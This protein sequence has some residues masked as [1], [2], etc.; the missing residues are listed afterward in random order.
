MLPRLICLLAF[1][2]CACAQPQPLTLNSLLKEMADRDALAR[3]PSPAYKQGQ[4]S[5]YNRASKARDQADQT[6]SGWFADGDGG[7]YMR[8]ENT[9]A[10][11]ATEYVV[12]EH[13]GP[14]AITK[15]W[16][17]FFYQDFN[18]R[19]GPNIR[20]YLNGSDTPVINENLI[21]LVTRL[22][23]STNE[24][25][26]K[27]SPRNSFTLPSPIAHFTARAGDCYLPVPFSTSCKVTISSAPFY[28]IVSYRAYPTGTLV[29]DFSMASLN[30]ASNQMQLATTIQQIATPTNFSGGQLFQA[31]QSILPGQSVSLT[32]NAG[33][34]AVRHLEVQLE[35]SQLQ[36]NP[37][38][39][40]ST[41]LAL[42]F[43]GEQTVWC[44]LGDFFCS[45]DQL[46][47]MQTWTRTVS[48]N[49]ASMVCRWVMPYQTSAKVALINLG[50]SPVSARLAVRTGEWA[51]N[52]RSMHFHANWRPD[53]VRPGTPPE[54]WNFIDIRGKG[55]F[56]GDAWTVLDIQPGTWWGEGDEKI[57]V[58]SEYDVPKFPGIFGTGTEDYYGWAGGVVPTRTDEF[59]SPY[60]AN[61]RVGGLDGHTLGYN[62]NT[63]VR[64]L[65]ALPFNQRLVFDMES[66]FGTD[67]RNKW[68]LLGY[69][70][71]VFWYALPGATHNRPAQPAAAAQPIQTISQLQKMS[72]AIR[73]PPAITNASP[74]R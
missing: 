39:L 58:D 53:D 60:L 66:S 74:R 24:Y 45:A 36:T 16:T 17:P 12:M 13:Q 10:G 67:I 34:A 4:G 50:G 28:D 26:A 48:T 55:V 29:E 73:F 5:T 9:N 33:A 57:Y 44:P 19:T 32:L 11:G 2:G 25:G 61:V 43:D 1:T 18:N 40:R 52:S 6:F 31:R 27:P 69:S 59:N 70:A 54:D 35:P 23:W 7:F 71:A 14:G 22:E 38:V 15:L 3:F 65:D 21:E 30:S 56:V 8:T 41:V 72:D 37:A 49:D 51:W 47:P 64:A 42:T 63:R 62:I 46:H 20:I 68:N